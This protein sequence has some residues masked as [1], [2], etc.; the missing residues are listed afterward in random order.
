M[1]VAYPYKLTDWKFLMVLPDGSEITVPPTGTFATE[2]QLLQ[3][4]I[5]TIN[6]LDS[7]FPSYS[8]TA[9]AEANNLGY[10]WV[11][12]LQKSI[13][14]QICK[15]G[16]IKCF[17]DG[18]GD[19]IHSFSSKIDGFVASAPAPLRKI[20]E[21]ITK[22]TTFVATGKSSQRF[23]TCRTC[24]GTKIWNGQ[25]NNLGRKERLNNE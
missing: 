15:R 21:A 8:S 3:A 17:G 16:N 18:V 25:K 10:D 4:L 23:G 9:R 7:Q 14:N 19:T 1:K 5:S 11:T 6:A 22:A 2:T 12:Y 24:G 13:H 20:G